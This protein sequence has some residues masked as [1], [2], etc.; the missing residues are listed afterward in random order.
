M[1]HGKIICVIVIGLTITPTADAITQW[2]PYVTGTTT[3]STII[4]WRTNN[5]TFGG[6]VKYTTKEYYESNMD[7]EY[8][9]SDNSIRQNHKL[10]LTDL[11]PDTLYYYQ[12]EIGDQSTDLFSFRT[13]PNE[14]SSFSFIVY[15][16]TREELPLF[17]QQERHKLVADMISQEGEISFVIHTGDLVS[18]GGD[19]KSWDG[20]FD[21]GKEM[22]AN[23]TFYPVLGN[24]EK[25]NSIYYE[26]FGVPDWYSF[27]CGDAHFT[28]LD[29]NDWADIS[30]ETTWLEEDLTSNSRFKFVTFHHPPYSSDQRHWGGWENVREFWEDLFIESGVDAVFSG[31]VH[32][33]ERYHINKVHY[34]VLGCGGAP[35]YQLSVEKIPG[36]QNSMESCLGY[37]RITVKE[38]EAKMEVIKVADISKEDGSVTNVYPPNTIFETL[39]L[40]EVLD[41]GMLRVTANVEIPMV[42]IDLNR[43][44]IDYGEVVA[45]DQSENETIK[46]V[47]RGSSEVRITLDVVAAS[48]EEQ[49]FYEESLYI[50]NNL[51]NQANITSSIPSDDSEDVITQLRI[52]TEWGI[53][54]KY[55]ANFVFWAEA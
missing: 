7:Y 23:T 40:E 10:V 45:G 1:R 20:F 41:R 21:A 8:S 9:I 2:G 42:G 12:L 39:I 49:D 24:H 47:N 54:S 34:I 28:M 35:M 5:E 55:D 50:N 27:Y 52:P 11:I 33:Y 46:I 32:T 13:F 18:D 22:M 51:Y 4:N 53:I 30:E 3:D 31:H 26:A 38:D 48:H 16:D 6:R 19:L 17:T 44:K 36:Y 15:G 29:S 43:S 37:A 25:N 14:G